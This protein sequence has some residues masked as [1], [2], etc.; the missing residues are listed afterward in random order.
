M[1]QLWIIA[2]IG[3]LLQAV[4][5]FM[6]ETRAAT[7]TNSSLP[8]EIVAVSTTNT[9][10][11][12]ALYRRTTPPPWTN[13]NALSFHFKRHNV[14]ELVSW[15]VIN[16]RGENFGEITRRLKMDTVEVAVVHN[17]PQWVTQ[18]AT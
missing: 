14:E 10:V 7:T 17:P 16:M 18:E 6:N 12:L 4:F 5:G 15:G 11:T 1:G 13:G 2:V 3:L 9:L 8:I